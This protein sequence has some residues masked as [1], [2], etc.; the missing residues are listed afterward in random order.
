[1]THVAARP[2][3]G[4]SAAPG[5]LLVCAALLFDL[6]GVLVHSTAPVER[7]WRRWATERGL[8][9]ET[10]L[11]R[12]HGRRTI[13]T[14]RALAPELNAGAEAA[15]IEVEQ[16]ADTDGVRAGA[17]AAALLASLP[18]SVWAVVTSCTAPLA[19]ARLAAARLPEPPHLI[20]AGDVAAGKPDPAGYRLGAAAVGQ[21]ARQCVVIEDAAAGIAAAHAAGMPAIGLCGAGPAEPVAAAEVV[22]SSL[23]G[24]V[25]TPSA[26]GLR[27][28][29]AAPVAVTL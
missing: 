13:D 25:V 19:R 14:V 4:S 1:M 5:A 12:A 28:R 7:S 23:A 11:A 6:D 15:R 8:P 17:G 21:P 26:D 10:V 29:I 2:G 24:L 27:L 20:S 22:V 9:P 16:S 3:G 18:R